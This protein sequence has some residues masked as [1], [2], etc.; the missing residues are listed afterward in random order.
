MMPL[1]F[2][3]AELV[4]PAF[5]ALCAAIAY[6]WNDIRKQYQE[7]RR[8]HKKCEEGLVEANKNFAELKEDFGLVKGRQ[9]GIEQM[10]RDVIREI[11][12]IRRGD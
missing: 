10:S 8:Q 12:S 1:P 4:I 3:Y 2:V 7:T 9:E 6:L 11:R 5:G